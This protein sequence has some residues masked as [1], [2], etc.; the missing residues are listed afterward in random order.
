M[1]VAIGEGHLLSHSTHKS[2]VCAVQKRLVC[3]VQKNPTRA[4]LL[5]VELQS[6]GRISK[7]III[8]TGR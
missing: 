8:N 4:A 5:R 3:V 1:Y 2:L 7:Y 6:P